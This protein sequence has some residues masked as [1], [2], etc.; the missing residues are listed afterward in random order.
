MIN[1]LLIDDDIELSQM[2][3]EYL[4]NEGF[5]IKSVYLGKD[6]INEALSGKYRAAIL[7]VML[8]DINGIDVLKNIRQQCNMPVIMLTAKGDNIDRVLGLELGADDYIPKPCYPRELLARLRAVL[9]RFDERSVETVDDKKYH[10]NGLT[11]DIPQ[12]LCTWN[13]QVID[14]T[15]TEFNLLVLLVKHNERVVTKEELSEIGLGRARELYDRSVDVHI[16][17]IRQKLYQVAQNDVTIETIRAVGYR[18]R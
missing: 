9:R 15:S 1:I 10:F 11:L 5:N 14:L 16:S 13:G 7:D 6:G 3:S 12:R 2:L 18:I 4:T 17:N 8:P